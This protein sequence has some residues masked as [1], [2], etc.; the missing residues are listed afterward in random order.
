MD[1]LVFQF[2]QS[3]AERGREVG[4]VVTE[5]AESKMTSQAAEREAEGIAPA[6]LTFLQVPAGVE[7]SHEVVCSGLL[8]SNSTEG[9]GVISETKSALASRSG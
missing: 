4:I 1:L 3:L 8:G 5:E 7:A 6:F 2:R 9:K